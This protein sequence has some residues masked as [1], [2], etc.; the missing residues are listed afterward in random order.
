MKKLSTSDEIFVWSSIRASINTWV[1]LLVTLLTSGTALFFAA[2]GVVL[3]NAD[4]L[5]NEATV[6]IT[7][8]F[9]LATLGFFVSVWHIANALS[10]V[11]RSAM[12]IEDSLFGKEENIYK[13]TTSVSKHPLWTRGRPFEEYCK[14]WVSGLLIASGA[15]T[16]W[17]ILIWINLT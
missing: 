11:A 1:G 12:A 10:I 6:F 15:L 13:L 9:F 17:Q 7:F 3:A 16:I 5:G 2:F 14:I 4:K 8:G